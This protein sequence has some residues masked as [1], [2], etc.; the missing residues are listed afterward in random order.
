MQSKQE[1]L[2]EQLAEVLLII[3]AMSRRLAGKLMSIPTRENANHRGA[4]YGKEHEGFA[5]P[6][7]E[8]TYQ[9]N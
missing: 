6:S 9:S 4:Q 8:H 2:D 1:Q 3:S 7:G 5:Q